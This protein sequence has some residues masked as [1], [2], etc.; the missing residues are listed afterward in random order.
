LIILSRRF[1]KILLISGEQQG[2]SKNF[3]H[4]ENTQKISRISSIVPSHFPIDKIRK[5]TVPLWL[6]NEFNEFSES[7]QKSC[8]R[9]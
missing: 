5:F 7:G 8:R 2:T 3:F 9:F 6:K 1:D 4:V